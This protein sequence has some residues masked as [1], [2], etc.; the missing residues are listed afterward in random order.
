MLVGEALNTQINV[1]AV[2][3]RIDPGYDYMDGDTDQYQ[4]V[5]ICVYPKVAHRGADGKFVIRDGYQLGV[6]KAKLNYND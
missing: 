4:L 3:S 5:V 6:E 2:C 1:S